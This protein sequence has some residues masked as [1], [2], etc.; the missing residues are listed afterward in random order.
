MLFEVMFDVL[1]SK[2]KTIKL[3]IQHIIPIT[4]IGMIVQAK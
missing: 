1:L 4:N 3:I 2:K